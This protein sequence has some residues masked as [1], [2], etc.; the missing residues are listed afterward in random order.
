MAIRGKY[1]FFVCDTIEERN[2]L[3][4]EIQ[5]IEGVQCYVKY[6]DYT[7]GSDNLIDSQHEYTFNGKLYLYVNGV[8][9]LIKTEPGTPLPEPTAPNQYLKVNE[10]GELVW[11][12][13]EGGVSGAGSDTFLDL[14]ERFTG[15]EAL[16]LG[17]RF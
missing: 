17:L 5:D 11:A 16:D 3:S 6:P 10:A 14:G 4:D 12:E 13:V 8:W 7:D 9:D 15:S 1:R 2:S